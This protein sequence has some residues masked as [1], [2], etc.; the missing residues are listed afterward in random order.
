MSRL[1]RASLS[2][3]AD[4]GDVPGVTSTLSVGYTSTSY[5]YAPNGILFDAEGTLVLVEPDAIKRYVASA[6]TGSGAHNDPPTTKLTVSGVA[7]TGASG[8]WAHTAVAGNGDFWFLC[9]AP[10]A[11]CRFS[12]ATL[13]AG[14]AATV[15]TGTLSVANFTPVSLAFDKDDN[16]WAISDTKLSGSRRPISNPRPT[17]LQSRL[18]ESTRHPVSRLRSRSSSSSTSF[19]RVAATRLS[20]S[21]RPSARLRRRRSRGRRARGRTLSIADVVS[22]QRHHGSRGEASD[23]RSA[24]SEQALAQ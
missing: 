10:K 19:V 18:S 14:G 2:A 1:D 16:L 22:F 9:G 5:N 17:R 24:S 4:G 13:A 21:T 3:A 8:V 11:L 12:K 6:L 23:S 20:T 7:E 15:P